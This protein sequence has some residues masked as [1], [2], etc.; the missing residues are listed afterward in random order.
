MPVYEFV[1]S[2]CNLKFQKVYSINDGKYPICPN[3]F[4][5]C[6]KIWRVFNSNPPIFKSSGFYS[7]D[8]K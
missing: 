2:K 1:C 7:K 5:Q 4:C 6:D 3:P 8:N